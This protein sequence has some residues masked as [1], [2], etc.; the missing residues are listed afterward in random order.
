MS[1]DRQ[2]SAIIVKVDDESWINESRV[3]SGLSNG[4]WSIEESRIVKQGMDIGND[5]NSWI[6][7]LSRKWRVTGVEEEK[8]E[9]DHEIDDGFDQVKEINQ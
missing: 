7:G 3:S 9:A 8:Q 2:Y 4:D 5:Y 1:Y 6:F